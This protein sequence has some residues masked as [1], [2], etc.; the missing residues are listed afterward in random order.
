MRT[1]VNGKV[2]PNA[3]L[4]KLQ[5]AILRPV[6]DALNDQV[7]TEIVSTEEALHHFEKHNS[8]EPRVVRDLPTRGN[9]RPRLQGNQKVIGS[10][11]VSALYPSCKAEKSSLKVEKA[12]RLSGLEFKHVN[13][14]FLV[15]V[16]SVITGGNHEDPNIREF[17]AKPKRRTTLNSFLK[18]PSWTKFEDTPI[19]NSETLSNLEENIL[20]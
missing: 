5:A 9:N 16:V 18:N 12:F 14:E 8:E 2:G 6:R 15:K 19:K 10:M 4:A 13:R 1:M 17:L 3:P 20:L 7:K 11:D